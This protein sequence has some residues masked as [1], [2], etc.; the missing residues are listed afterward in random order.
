MSLNYFNFKELNG[1]VL[2]TNDLGNHVFLTK[3]EFKALVSETIDKESE[4]WKN[5]IS[6]RMVYEGST[7]RFSEIAQNELREIKNHCGIATSLHIFVVTTACN[8]NCVYCQANN[9]EDIPNCFMSKETARKAVD[10]ALQ[11]PSHSLSFEFQGGEPLL[12]YEV[13]KEIIEY[14]EETN[15]SHKISF[16]LVSNLSLLTEEMLDYFCEHRVSISTSID[17]TEDI[18]NQNRPFKDGRGSFRTAKEAIG[19][20]RKKGLGVGAIETTTRPALS[21][22]KDL[23]QTYVEL[24]FDSIFIRPLTQLGK[25]KRVWDNIGYTAEEFLAFYMDAVDEILRINK[26]GV[27][28]REQH[29]SILLQRISGKSVNYMELRSPCGGGVGQLAYFSDGRIYTCDE[30][31]MLSEMGDQSFFLGDVDNSTYKSIIQNNVCRAVCASSILETIPSCCDCVYQPYCGTCPVVNYA[32]HGDVIEKT[33]RS[34]RCK[35]YQGILDYLFGL[36]MEGDED[37]MEVINEWSM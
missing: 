35:V 11:S 6:T 8:M 25:A 33:P 18:H 34:F 26:N 19:R 36:I 32:I 23:I 15:T 5:L 22:A 16:N 21:K 29:A 30:G 10:I 2:L 13:I 4:T 17:G 9:G 37:I 1:K 7:L 14:T 12:N 3:D 31:R 20:V 27:Y 24:G 28:F